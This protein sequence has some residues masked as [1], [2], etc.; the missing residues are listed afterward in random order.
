MS[1][2]KYVSLSKL[3][4]FLDNLYNKFSSLGHKHTLSDITNYAVDSQLSSNSTNPV[5]N[6]VV[7]AEFEA[8]SNAMN[9]LESAIDGKSDSGHTHDDKYYTETEIDNK[10]N[11]Y[12]PNTRKVNGKV[13]NA[14]IT[15]SA[16]DVGAYSQTEIDNM[17]FITVDDIDEICGATI[18]VINAY[19]ERF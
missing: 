11:G 3:S 7:D 15:L 13:L 17:E 1:Q 9:A 8:I 6:K 14:D 19:V 5:Q 12:V 2:K 10:L 4:T 18:P 16:S